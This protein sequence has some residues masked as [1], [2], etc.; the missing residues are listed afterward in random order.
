MRFFFS[1]LNSAGANA[2]NKS[3]TFSPEKKKPIRCGVT[4]FIEN[5]SRFLC[6]FDSIL[7]IFCFVTD[8]CEIV[9]AKHSNSIYNLENW[10]PY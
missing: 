8:K 10:K 4:N 5:I 9:P 2:R 7:L 6:G 3:H 1:S